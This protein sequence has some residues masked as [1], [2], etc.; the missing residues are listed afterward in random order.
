MAGGWLGWDWGTVP[1][2]IGTVVTSSSVLIAAVAYRRSVLD[3]ER[4]QAS[5]VAAWTSVSYEPDEKEKRPQRTRRLYVHNSS[6]A[7][8]YEVTV[9]PSDARDVTLPEL[10]GH[11]SAT[12]DLPAGTPPAGASVREARAGLKIW[13]VAVEAHL[14]SEVVKQ[15]PTG[16]EFRDALGRW[17]ARDPSGK[18]KSLGSRTVTGVYQSK[19]GLP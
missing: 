9:R 11:G 2:W 12:F 14:V 18:L 1:A 19:A 3:K 17:W 8:I 7:P 13:V 15:E 6:D 16:L 10:Q 5:K 4:E